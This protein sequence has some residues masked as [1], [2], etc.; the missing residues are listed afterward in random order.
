MGVAG[1]ARKRKKHHRRGRDL[2]S[3]FIS[4]TAPFSLV[5]ATTEDIPRQ[6]FPAE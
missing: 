2:L 3:R 1:V 6:A 4:Q 5:L